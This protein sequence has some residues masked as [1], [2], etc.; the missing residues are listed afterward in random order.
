MVTDKDLHRIN[1]IIESI[2]KIETIANNCENLE[3][4]ENKWIEQD[5]MIRN[6]EIIGEASNHLSTRLKEEHP[7]IEWAKIVGMRNLI[8]HEYF[9][10]SPKVIWNTAVDIIPGLRRKLTEIKGNSK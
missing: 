10:V 9:G 6:F 2:N 3:T 7:E 5:A 4:F 8:A 1:H